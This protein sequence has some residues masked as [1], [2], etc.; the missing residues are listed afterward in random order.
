MKIQAFLA[1]IT[2]SGILVFSLL[3]KIKKQ[4]HEIL[5]FFPAK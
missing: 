1:K 4:K 2:T 5:R 3:A